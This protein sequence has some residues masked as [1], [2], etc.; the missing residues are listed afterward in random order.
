M[1][2]ATGFDL[3]IFGRGKIIKEKEMPRWGDLITGIKY[4]TIYTSKFSSKES[5]QW[6]TWYIIE[7]MKWLRGLYHLAFI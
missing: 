2:S 1:N 7:I 4:E 3:C 6:G 5:D